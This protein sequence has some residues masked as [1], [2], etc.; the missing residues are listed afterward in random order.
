MTS[1]PTQTKNAK[2]ELPP[3]EQ[4]RRPEELEQVTLSM[5]KPEKPDPT[6]VIKKYFLTNPKLLR[7]WKKNVIRAIER[8]YRK[9]PNKLLKWKTKTTAGIK[10]FY[11]QQIR[12]LKKTRKD[13]I[14][15]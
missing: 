10:R 7:K 14:E 3:E 9:D 4:M 2:K 13:L 5:P 11:R 1:K 8:R 15:Q 12:E 6:I